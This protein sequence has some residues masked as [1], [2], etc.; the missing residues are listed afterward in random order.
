[1]GFLGN[2]IWF[3]CA[4]FWQ[5]LGWLIAGFLWNLTIV[6]IPIGRQCFKFA[7]LSF[8]PFGLEVIP[9]GGLPSA[10]MNMIWL[11]VSGLWLALT[12]FVNG[13]VLC[14]TIIGIPFGLQC[15]KHAKLALCPFGARIE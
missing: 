3:L 6:G 10:V 9:G 13:L 1:M 2:V 12:A 15:F 5:G 11:V 8:R 7:V 4:G 14:C